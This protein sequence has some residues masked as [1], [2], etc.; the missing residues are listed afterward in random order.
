MRLGEGEEIASVTVIEPRDP[1]ATAQ[2]EGVQEA[3]IG[4]DGAAPAPE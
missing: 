2:A 4:A 1:A 3:E